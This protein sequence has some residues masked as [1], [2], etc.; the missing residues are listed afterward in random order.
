[1]IPK[2]L[3]DLLGAMFAQ[4]YSVT[5]PA[6]LLLVVTS[7]LAL[8]NNII[9]ALL[10]SYSAWAWF[11]DD[12]PSTGS[13]AWLQPGCRTWTITRLSLETI[14]PPLSNS[15]KKRGPSLKKNKTSS[16]VAV[17]ERNPGSTSSARTRTA[18]SVPAPLLHSSLPSTSRVS[19]RTS[20]QSRKVIATFVEP[21]FHSNSF[22]RLCEN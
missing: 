7:Y 16:K 3:K 6:T 18:A 8:S 21:P 20:S 13:R 19:F 9:A 10:I 14:S 22:R 11:I 2:P 4:H 1:M 5:L 17:R 12:A 15:T